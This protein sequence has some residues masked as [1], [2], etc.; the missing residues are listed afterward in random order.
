MHE[1]SIALSIIDAVTAKAE[2]EKAGK[3]TGIELEVGRI[4]G[5]QSESL[6]FCLPVAA[7]NTVAE[8]ADLSIRETEPEGECE[9]CGRR[10]PMDGFFARCEICGSLDISIV[11]GRELLIKSITLE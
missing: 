9:E 4:S 11:S 6:R 8:G 7:K 3:V 2:E 10:F 5:V 1:M